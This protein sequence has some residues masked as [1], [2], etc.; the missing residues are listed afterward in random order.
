M[1]PAPHRV[2]AG[3]FDAL[4]TGG[5]DVDAVRH[6]AAGQ[7]SKNLLLFH[8]LTSQVAADGHPDARTVHE[9]YRALVH[10][11]KAAPQSTMHVLSYPAVE[12]WVN[13][14]VRTLTAGYPEHAQP[15]QI[16]AVAAAAAIRGRV[17][18]TVDLSAVPRSGPEILLPS[19]GAA[20]LPGATEGPLTLRWS[21]TGAQLVSA[22]GAVRVPTDWHT[23]TRSWTGLPRISAHHGDL[24]FEAL[25]D[26]LRWLPPLAAP[27]LD[28]RLADQRAVDVELW[29]RQVAGGWQLLS[30]GHPRVAREV[31]EA[32]SVLAPLTAT[33]TGSVSGSFRDAFGVIAMSAPFRAHDV[34]V[35]FAHEIQHAK[36][37]ALMDLIPL[38]RPGPDRRYHAPWRDDP[39]P[40]AAL[41]HGLYAHVGIAAFWRRQ[42][43]RERAEADALRAQ[44]EFARWR[45]ACR[46]VAEVLLG[47]DRLTVP[48]RRFVS[49]LARVLQGWLRD[50]IPPEALAR[51]ALPRRSTA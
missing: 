28:A 33:G 35:T 36:L 2:P 25:L 4:A 8:V 43:H 26:G 6:L 31:A 3:T 21:E 7:R 45:V 18:I 46:D 1:T 23:T 10:I 27:K 44:I 38:I 34:A 22:T 16:S 41:L 19:V 17:P 39:R 20:Y 11:Q 37:S 50:P 51:A 5:G 15:A 9:G 48:G 29:R 14:A 24:R 32:I 30:G 13:H 42:R 49:G 47:E 12:A 40:L